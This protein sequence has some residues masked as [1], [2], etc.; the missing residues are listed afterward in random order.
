[1]WLRLQD[2]RGFVTTPSL[3]LSP[4]QPHG[5][6]VQALPE[7]GVPARLRA[8]PGLASPALLIN[9]H[10]GSD[11]LRANI[12]PHCCLLRLPELVEAARHAHAD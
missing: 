12:K 6:F 1:M 2:G 5:V 9:P 11:A 8:A 10:F 3:G 7:R 4:R